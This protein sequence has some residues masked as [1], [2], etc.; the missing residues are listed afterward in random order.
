MFWKTKADL[1]AQID[2]MECYNRYLQGEVRRQYGKVAQLRRSAEEAFANTDRNEKQ[3]LLDVHAMRRDDD[4]DF[5]MGW[6]QA[7]GHVEKLIEEL[8]GARIQDCVEESE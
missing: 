8:L 2:S 7:V 6:N 1:R 3:L 5:S 4:G